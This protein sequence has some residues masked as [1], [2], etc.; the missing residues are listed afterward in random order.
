MKRFLSVIALLLTFCLLTTCLFGCSD[1]EETEKEDE[2]ETE[3]QGIQGEV[4]Q[5]SGTFSDCLMLEKI[6]TVDRDDFS[7]YGGGLV[8]K[9]KETN[10]YGIISS[11]GVVDSG[12]VYDYVESK[13][14][15]FA[16]LADAASNA[17]DVSG[18]NKFALV[19]GR[20][21]QLV[22]PGHASYYF[23]GDF[24][25]AYTATTRDDANGNVKFYKG[26][27]AFASELTA[28]VAYNSKWCVYNIKTGTQ[29]PGL[30]GTGEFSGFGEG[31][32]LTYKLN[33]QFITVDAN[34]N[35]APED[36]EIFDDGSYAIEGQIGEVFDSNGN[37][38]FGYD[39]TGYIPSSTDGV[40]YVA[41]RYMDGETTSVIM[42]KTGAVVSVEYKGYVDLVGELVL[43]DSV[44]Y[45]FEGKVMLDGECGGVKQD[46]VFGEYYVAHAGDVYTVLDP[47]GAVYLSMVFDD[48]HTFYSDQFL[49]SDKTS[50]DY[51]Y[52]NHKT[53]Q[54][55]I[56][57]YSLAP[58]VVKVVG[59]NNTYELVDTM[60]GD[61]MLSG[62]NNYSY[63]ARNPETYYIY[64]K[65]NGGADVF[66]ATSMNGFK[67]VTEMK[68]DLLDDL[69]AAFEAE[70]LNVTVN[71]ETGEISMDSSVLF[72]GD[73]S[74]LTDEGKAFLNK[75]IKAY[76]SVA[77]SDKYDGFI[78]KTMIEGHTAPTAN[79]TYASGLP[80]SQERAAN[81]KAY[82]L[83]G[84]TGVDLSAKADTFEDVGYS[85]SQPIL[86]EDGSVNMDASRRV[87]FRFLV[88]VDG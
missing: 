69:S 30:E 22:A 9:D 20:G 2:E 56:K 59:A 3:E 43:C 74:A 66:L 61:V 16:V 39:L 27:D 55:D 31:S 26:S 57:G 40:H 10:K 14:S 84:E 63:N 64:A 41:K 18:L 86:N 34:G 11:D 58:W 19:D 76:N 73:S 24:V 88:N 60:T 15:C 44:L 70:G 53:Q 45:N 6:G 82:I 51:M 38:L 47:T 52:Y 5:V 48:T 77:F 36:A 79:S 54:Y 7:T 13:G 62:Y 1:E 68:E 35:P 85:N 8:Y 42:D 49:A 29:I 23:Y 4:Q 65:Y 67:S 72:G 28:D 17:N 75:F 78:S 37:K 21:R 80:L 81:V 71:R 12:A 25:V 50:G 46:R 33:D 32:F 87:S 83:S